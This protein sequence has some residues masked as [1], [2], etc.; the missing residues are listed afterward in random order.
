MTKVKKFFIYIYAISKIKS[1]SVLL[2]EWRFQLCK[3]NNHIYCDVATFYTVF[4][5]HND[6]FKI[7]K[8]T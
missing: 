4:S 3:T 2:E 6:I 1:Y 8:Y 5:K 7:S